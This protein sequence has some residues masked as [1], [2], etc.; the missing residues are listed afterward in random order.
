LDE[1]DLIGA[2]EYEKEIVNTGV[3]GV[4]RARIAGSNFLDLWLEK[5]KNKKSYA[6]RK[7]LDGNVPNKIPDDQAEF[8]E[9]LR[10]RSRDA[11]NKTMQRIQKNLKLLEFKI[12]P[13]SI[14][15]CRYKEFTSLDKDQLDLTKIFHMRGLA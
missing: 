8:N 12:I 5:M 2:K 11:R 1:F 9:L 6:M 7:S 4:N 15:N 14:Y 3:L 10:I 13:S